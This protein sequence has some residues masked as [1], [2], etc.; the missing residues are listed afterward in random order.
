MLTSCLYIWSWSAKSLSSS[1]VKALNRYLEGHGFKSC[2]G[3]LRSFFC[4]TLI[5]LFIHFIIY[6]LQCKFTILHL[7]L[8]LVL[9]ICIT[10]QYFVR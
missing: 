1:V 9:D 2:G 5:Y 10:E 8:P 6:S 4:S 3:G 7:L